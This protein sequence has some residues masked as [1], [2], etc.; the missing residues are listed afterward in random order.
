MAQAVPSINRNFTYTLG[1]IMRRLG[2]DRTDSGRERGV[3]WQIAY[4]TQLITLADFP[5]PFPLPIQNGLTKEVR[6]SSRWNAEAVDYWFTNQMNPAAQ[7]QAAAAQ[8]NAA[9][10]AMD[11]RAARLGNLTLIEG[12]AA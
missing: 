9:A 2:Q 12:G 1:A 8:I 4:V 6:P 7:A 5:D 3:Q 11:D 10:G